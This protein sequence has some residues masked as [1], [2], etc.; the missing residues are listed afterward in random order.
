MPTITLDIPLLIIGLLLLVWFRLCKPDYRFQVVCQLVGTFWAQYSFIVSWSLLRI[1]PFFAASTFPLKKLNYGNLFV[2]FILY[3]LFVTLISSLFWIIS[4]DTWFAYGEG[5]LWIQLAIFLSLVLSARAF[6]VAMSEPRGPLLMWKA[7]IVMGIIHGLASGYQYIAWFTGL[8]LIEISLAHEWGLELGMTDVVAAFTIGDFNIIRPAGLAGEPR[9]ASALFGIVLLAAFFIGRP[10]TIT[11]AWL[12]L[13]TISIGLATLGFI[14]AFS[15]SG[16]VG[17]VVGLVGLGMMGAINLI[18]L[19]R[20]IKYVLCLMVMILILSYLLVAAGYPSLIDLLIMRSVERIGTAEM[21][22]LPNQAAIEILFSNWSVFFFGT[23]IGGGTFFVQD[24]LDLSFE[25][26]LMPTIGALALFL[27]IG[28]IGTLLLFIPFFALLVMARK[29]MRNINSQNRWEM[30]FLLTLAIT[31]MIFMLA[32]SSVGALGYPVAIGS[33][34]GAVN[35]LQRQRQLA[36]NRRETIH[37]PPTFQ[38][39]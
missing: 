15:T 24:A 39:K 10:P 30:R 2:P 27:E 18:S 16:Y 33:I 17:F 22:Y 9:Y 11:K 6:A 36:M 31:A 35:F 14:G 25:Y 20:I 7:L 1:A 13:S 19:S 3:A 8:P 38:K 23:G 21:Y 37:L 32:G 12:R 29:K 26:A 5:R 34:L 4:P 28:L